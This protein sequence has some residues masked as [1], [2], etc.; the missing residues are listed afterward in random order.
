[1]RKKSGFARPSGPINDGSITNGAPFVGWKNNPVLCCNSAIVKVVFGVLL[2]ER[3][4]RLRVPR[5][6]MKEIGLPVRN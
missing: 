6:E 1:M 3:A 4:E 2:P 5:P